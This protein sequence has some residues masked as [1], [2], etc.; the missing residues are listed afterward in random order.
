[1]SFVS[2]SPLIPAY[3]NVLKDYLIRKAPFNK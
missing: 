1:M 2:H 3:F